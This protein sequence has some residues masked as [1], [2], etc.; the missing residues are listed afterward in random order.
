[1]M[2]KLLGYADE[3]PERFIYATDWP[4]ANDGGLQAIESWTK[5]VETPRLVVVD[6]LAMFRSPR[7]VKENGYEADFSAISSLQRAAAEARVAI[8]V[9]HHLRKSQD[10]VDPFEKI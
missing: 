2:T 3:W 10:Q 5:R 9:V 8:V 4:R 6:V 1:R 7:G